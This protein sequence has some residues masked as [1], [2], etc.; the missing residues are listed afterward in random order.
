MNDNGHLKTFLTQTVSFMIV[1]FIAKVQ[2]LEGIVLCLLGLDLFFL[3]LLKNIDCGN[4][5]EPP[6]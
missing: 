1:I 2:N 6:R 4:L 3:F 5:L